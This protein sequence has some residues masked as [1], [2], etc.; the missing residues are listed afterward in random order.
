MRRSIPHPAQIC[1]V[2]G[3]AL[4]LSCSLAAPKGQEATPTTAP[5]PSPPPTQPSTGPTEE[6]PETNVIEPRFG[7]DYVFPLMAYYQQERWPKT[8]SETG[9]KWV[10]FAAVSWESIEP[11]PPAGGAHKYDWTGLDRSVRLW[12]K[13][14]FRIVV[15]SLR[16]GNG[17]FAGPIRYTPGIESPLGEL[18]FNNSDRL[19]ADEHMDSYRAWIAGLVERYDNDGREDMPGLR[20]PI[21]YCQAGNEVLRRDR[22]GRSVSSGFAASVQVSP[23]ADSPGDE[24]EP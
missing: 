2:V 18:Y 13:Y 1:L 10:N 9:A 5:P 11:R 21:L 15:M 14:D 3:L 12:Q 8:Y 22:L 17:W 16:L 19:P 24:C 4:M 20:Y 7:I 23:V 6:T